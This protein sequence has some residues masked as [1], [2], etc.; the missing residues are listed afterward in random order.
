M[1]IVDNNAVRRKDRIRMAAV[2]SFLDDVVAC[3]HRRN[4][5][6]LHLLYNNLHLLS[7]LSSL[8]IILRE[9]EANSNNRLLFLPLLLLSTTIAEVEILCDDTFDRLI[10]ISSRYLEKAAVYYQCSNLSLQKK[11]MLHDN[12]LESIC[13][14]GIP[15]LLIISVLSVATEWQGPS[16]A[17]FLY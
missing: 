17:V 1:N 9:A 11:M 6:A 3:F 2:R 12:Q 14:L 15:T 7:T 16:L 13:I 5:A 8:P 10:I 4:N